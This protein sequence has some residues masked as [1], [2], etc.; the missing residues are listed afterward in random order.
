MDKQITVIEFTPCNI[1]LLSGYQMKDRLYVL[2]S[3]EGEILP[4]NPEGYPKKEDL[5]ES[6]IALLATARKQLPVDIG[7]LVFLYPPYG[8]KAKEKSLKPLRFQGF[9]LVREAGLEFN[10]E[11]FQQQITSN[12]VIFS[13]ETIKHG[14]SQSSCFIRDNPL[15]GQ[16][17]GQIRP[18]ERTIT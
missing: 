10:K 6:L 12:Y 8:F 5:K 3:L 7:P 1:K 9:L 17:K 18:R 11:N 14:I 13:S 4:L 16:N 2:Q 15:K